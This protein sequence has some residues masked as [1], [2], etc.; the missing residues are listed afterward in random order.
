MEKW[1]SA[2]K[3]SNN[4]EM[5]Q[6]GTILARLLL[7]T[8]RKSHIHVRLVPKSAILDNL[9]GRVLALCFKTRAQ[10]CCYLFIFSFT[11]NL[12]LGNK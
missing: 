6:D 2:Y 11:F 5:W 10:W 8:N 9:E 4:F 3:S 7:R 12:L 1:L